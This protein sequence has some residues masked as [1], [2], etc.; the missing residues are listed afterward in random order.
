MD[1]GLGTR[2]QFGSQELPCWWSH[3]ADLQ[4]IASQETP[5]GPFSALQASTQVPVWLLR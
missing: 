1:S 3:N 5:A 2:L 4:L